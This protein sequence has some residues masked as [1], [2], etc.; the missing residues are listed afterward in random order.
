MKAQLTDLSVRALKPT[1][2]QYK[3]WDTRTPG[4]GIRVN[5]RTKS[6]VV[7]Y[8]AKRRMKVL[9][10]YPDTPLATARKTALV[11]LGTRPDGET[12]SPLF[13]DVLPV[14]LDEN[15]AGKSPRT[16]YQVARLLNNH[17]LPEFTGTR[18]AK[19]ADTDIT[20]VL[21]RLNH[22]PSE[23]LHAF[24][25]IRTMLNWCTRAPRRHITRNPLDGYQAPGQDKKGTRTL[26][27]DELTRVWH[28]CGK[29]S[30]GAVVKLLILWGTRN[31]ETGRIERAWVDKKVIVI[32]GA[33]TK[34]GRDHAIPILP[35]AQA[36]LDKLAYAG[37]FYFPGKKHG[38]H[39]NDGSWGKFKYEL[40]ELSGVKDW[41][42]RDI[43]R[44]FRSTMA[45]LKVP[46]H[47]AE[48]LINH[49]T[50]SKNELDE[51]YD[52]YDY[53]EEKREALE[54]YERHLTALFKRAKKR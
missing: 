45:K 5:G 2:E 21:D 34:N 13:E 10:R 43:R 44:T 26:T 24:R 30:L 41:D 42:F 20:R 14:F 48:A 12:K 46:R 33:V 1:G 27:D 51:I 3:V 18:I 8:G 4:F 50:G 38:T 16:K 49:V 52:R 32:P 22:V 25:A 9:G 54:R 29:L 6:W 53:L 15:Y 31:G 19:I 17:F 35:M 28:A 36:V 47:I 40:D 39:L 7:M 23:K 37:R 11:I